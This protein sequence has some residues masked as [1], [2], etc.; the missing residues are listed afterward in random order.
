MDAC[1]RL[2][3]GV[4]CYEDMGSMSFGSAEVLTILVCLGAQAF[5]WRIGIA[6]QHEPMVAPNLGFL[7]TCHSAHY[8]PY[9]HV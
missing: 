1:L 2:Y 5:S 4:I 3:V 7:L 8:T 9:V 6:G